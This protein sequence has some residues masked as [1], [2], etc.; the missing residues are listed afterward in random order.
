MS[1]TPEHGRLLDLW[2][3]L[4]TEFAPGLTED[5]FE[6]IESTNGFRFPP[7]LRACLASAMP[8]GKSFPNWRLANAYR[9]SWASVRKGILFDVRQ[10]DWYERFGSR[11]HLE[12]EQLAIAETYF[13]RVPKLAPVYSH[14]FLPTIPC[15]AGNPVF[16]IHQTD[17]IHYGEDLGGYLEVEFFD[18]PHNT[19]DQDRL[20]HIE[21]WTDMVEIEGWDRFDDAASD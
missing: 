2:H 20:R 1:G 7:D 19:I 9:D 6:S 11:P 13:A 3:R 17:A 14:R 18:R 21:F 8:T 12:D 5:E 10:G 4:P 16:S 15:E